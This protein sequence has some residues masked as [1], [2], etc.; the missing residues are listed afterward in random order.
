MKHGLMLIAV[1]TATPAFA[2]HEAV[3]ATSLFPVVATLTTLFITGL[4]AW[5]HRRKHS[6][7]HSANHTAS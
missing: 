3:V 4:A 5:R 1:V 6:K 2:H 7:A